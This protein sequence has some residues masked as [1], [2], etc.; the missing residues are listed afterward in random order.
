MV[1]WLTLVKP[2]KEEFE[3]RICAEE[4]MGA[5]FNLMVQVGWL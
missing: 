5:L 3:A 4:Q 2:S 1:S